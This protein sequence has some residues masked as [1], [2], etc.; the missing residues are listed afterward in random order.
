MKIAAIDV[1]SNSI[2]LVIVEADAVGNQR[3]LAREKTMVRLAKG[4]AKT[5]KIA[6]EAF[7]AGLETL[8]LMAEVI[9]GFSC[10]TTMAC[11]TAAL[12]EAGNADRFI[13]EAGALGIPIR[14]IS[15]EE[16]ARLIHLA[17][18]RAIPFPDEPS[19]L[20]D[21]GGGSTELTWVHGE[22]V[23][24]SI[25]LPW[26]LQRLADAVPTA[27]PP[28]PDDMARLGKFI[29]KVLKKA[30]KALPKDLPPAS[31]VLGTSG[32]LLDLAK[33]TG[34]T[35]A[36]SREQLLRFER[37]LWR[38]TAQERVTNLGVDPKRAEVLHVGATW[39]MGI[40]RWLEATQVRCLPVGLREGM[41]WEALR[42]GGVALPALP[43]RR[44]Q[45]VETLAERLDPDPGHSRHV[46]TL[47]DQLFLDLRP[48]FELGETEREL[49]AYAAR[50]HDIGLSVAE[51]SHHKHGAYLIQNANL[52]G[53]WP[54]ECELISQV[55]RFHR[56]KAPDMRKHEGFALL[57]PWHR[58]VVEKL[59]A[60]LRVADAL[61]RRRRQSVRLVRLE[62]DAEETRLM[63]H[64]SGD[65]RPELEAL[66]DKGKLL[67]NLLDRPLQVVVVG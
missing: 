52:A 44:R 47:A 12:R 29:R 23:P 15:G 57:A 25:S 20:V 22:R 10:D 42:H 67:F 16:E 56:G 51:K 66:Q 7:Q 49:L 28:T 59:A 64:G 32:T 54:K 46:Q 37:K 31:I 62:T 35:S 55:V 24:A 26:G 60:I 48:A 21:I 2:H 6:P 34:E 14:V 40:L 36:F 63:V 61:D 50:L 19:V 4:I 43:E 3:V 45:S 38:C 13:E 9:R 65:L 30:M 33:G 27:N 11:G 8:A 1:G 17:V 41:I 5:G 53:F 39:A 18:S 58:Q